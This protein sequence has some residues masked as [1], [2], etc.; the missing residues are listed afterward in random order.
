MSGCHQHPCQHGPCLS[1]PKE[2]YH[3]MFCHY[4]QGFTGHLY[5]QQIDKF[6]QILSDQI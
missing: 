6:C 4:D 3:Y 2:G 5:N 1:Q